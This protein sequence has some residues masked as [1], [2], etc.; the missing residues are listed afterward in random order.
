MI[1]SSNKGS[2]TLRNGPDVAANADFTFYVCADQTT[3]AAN[4]LGGTSFAAPM[5]A[6]YLAL[7]NQQAAVNGGAPVG[8]INPTIYAQNVTARY[9]TD[10]HDTSSGVSGSYSA[11]AG[12]DLVTGWGSPNGSGLIGA[13]TTVSTAASG[14]NVMAATAAESLALGK[15]SSVVLTT[16]VFGGFSSAVALSAVGEPAGVRVS[17]SPS[18]IEAPGGGTSKMTV[19]V[20]RHVV[21]DTYPITITAMGGGVAHT[22]TFDLTVR[23]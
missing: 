8:F 21:P 6:G 1:N 11:V 18:S 20:G 2:T 23:R 4:Q 16:S 12:Y 7:V 3:C 9:A 14:F 22:V 10:F 19:A 5:W 15:S 13:L 17:F